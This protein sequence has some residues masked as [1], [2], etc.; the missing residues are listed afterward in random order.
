MSA[1]DASGRIGRREFLTRSALGAA[2]LALPRAP[3]AAMFVSLP[4]WAVA[5]GVVW[6][7]Q[8]RLA[9]RVGYAGIDWAFGPAKTAGV[10][11]TRALLAEL[12]IVPTITNLPMQGTLG[13]DEAAFAAQ[14]PTLDQDAAFCR[15]IGCSRFQLVLG[16]TTPN[17][18][19]KAEHWARVRRRLSAV[20]AVLAPHDVR[21]GLE[22]L[23][24][25]VFRRRREGTPPDAPPPVPFVWT[26][27]ETLALCEASGPN[28][29]VT[30]D[31]WHWHHA[32]GTTTDIRAASA[33]RIVHV[34]VSDARAMPPDDV[35]DDMRLLPG[36]GVIDLV[37]FF[38]ALAA[39]GYRGGVAPE[40]IGPRIPDGMSPEDS[41]R[42]ALEA[43]MAVLRRAGVT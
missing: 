7:E 29:G 27:P 3:A 24:P 41:A 9:A 17:G 1:S 2:A 39:I 28:V 23:G 35:R 22:F 10:E 12:A 43:T 31:A 20:A 40:T 42:L 21:L 11:A 18:Q 13:P 15:A 30:L 8:A 6:P 19:P 4:P 32:G 34:H 38:Q 36:E 16:A 37:G 33:S 26:L 14:L 25:R 5:R